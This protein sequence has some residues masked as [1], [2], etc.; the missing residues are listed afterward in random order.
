MAVT[1][2]LEPR[3]HALSEINGGNQIGYQELQADFINKSLE[4]S[5][6]ASQTAKQ[7][8]NIAKDVES[9]ANDGEFIGPVGPAGPQG[10]ASIIP[11]PPG[12]TSAA[13]EIARQAQLA[14]EAAKRAAEQAA[15]TGGSMVYTGGVFQP[16][17]ETNTKAS[18]DRFVQPE[19]G[20]IVDL[21]AG[22]DLAGL[23][24]LLLDWSKNTLSETGY[25][26][27]VG[28]QENTPLRAIIGD[29]LMGGYVRVGVS[30]DSG[31][32]NEG[33]C[34]SLT[35]FDGFGVSP[36]TKTKTISKYGLSASGIYQTTWAEPFTQEVKNSLAPIA[37]PAFTGTPTVPT[38]TA[39]AGDTQAVNVEY[40]RQAISDVKN[41]TEG[42]VSLVEGF[43][44]TTNYVKRQVNFIIGKI[45]GFNENSSLTL[46]NIPV[47][48]RPTQPVPI[49]V[50]AMFTDTL[51]RHAAGNINPNGDITITES[52]S[53]GY[54]RGSLS[55]DFGYEIT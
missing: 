12:D 15:E 21:L 1:P 40:V 30:V 41:I 31:I 4:N 3:E 29:P 51:N 25:L 2:P 34:F 14:A 52:S 5:A 16:T 39:T 46:G 53:S 24:D 9:R 26:G 23:F 28:T 6:F 8:I 13:E 10:Q 55:I 35:A 18:L 27:I 22:T 43:T 48:F 54:M 49:T 47:G 45:S 42:S 20:P 17:F 36:I 38:P 32:Q 7:S 37:S 19:S 33:T 50:W 44:A 11:G